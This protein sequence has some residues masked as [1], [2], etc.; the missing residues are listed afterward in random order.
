MEINEVFKWVEEN[1]FLQYKAQKVDEQYQ[2]CKKDKL[3]EYELFSALANQVLN[4][5][6]K[7]CL[8]YQIKKIF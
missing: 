1:K 5:V 4:I 3:T 8:L 6:T 7:K 2:L